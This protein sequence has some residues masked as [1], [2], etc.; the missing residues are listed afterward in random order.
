M[1]SKRGRIFQ[2]GSIWWIQYFFNKQ[3]RRESTRSTKRKVA[4]KL[5]TKRM[6]GK[7]AGTLQ[8]SSLTPL[9]FADLQAAIE[10]DYLLNQRSSLDRLQVAFKALG[11]M[12]S[13]WKAN[14]ITKDRLVEFANTR[15]ADGKAHA[16]VRYELACLR[17][18]FRLAQVPCPYFPSIQVQ[19]TRTGF[20]EWP[21]FCTVRDH[22]PEYLHAP[23]TV[24]YYTGW[25]VKSELLPLQWSHVDW[26]AG[27]ITL[28]AGTTKNK[29][30]RTYYFNQFPE[31]LAVITAQRETAQQIGKARGCIVPWVFFRVTKTTVTPIKSYKT[32]WA[33]ATLASGLPNRL[34]HDL[35]RTGVRSLRHAGIPE[36]VAMQLTGHKTRAVFDR[37]DIV[38]PKEREEA[39]QKLAAFHAH[40]VRLRDNHGTMSTLPLGKQGTHD[41]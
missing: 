14:A 19:N 30:S 24:G 3:D 28:D 10:G 40:D 1:S 13:G 39:V 26:K 37:Y 7:D 6:A 12:F 25:R 8:V 41:R 23:M 36:N 32:A 2:R 4:E 34:V 21:D 17:H 27:T 16:T 33:R 11:A 18:A 22:L 20:F 31:L 38:E 5:L 9:T 15:I 29:Q 35:R